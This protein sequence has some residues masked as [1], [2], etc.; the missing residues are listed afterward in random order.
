MKQDA[1]QARDEKIRRYRM[2]KEC[3]KRLVEIKM[4]QV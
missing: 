3:E 4:L 1:S 2:E